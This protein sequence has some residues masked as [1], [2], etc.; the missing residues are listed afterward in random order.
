MSSTTLTRTYIFTYKQLAKKLG[1]EGKILLVERGIGLF[2]R[3]CVSIK[4]EVKE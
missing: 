4:E 3:P 2:D 1:I